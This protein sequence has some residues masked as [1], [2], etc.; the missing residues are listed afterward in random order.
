[1]FRHPLYFAH[2]LAMTNI[3]IKEVLTNISKGLRR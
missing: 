3:R 2:E 1:M